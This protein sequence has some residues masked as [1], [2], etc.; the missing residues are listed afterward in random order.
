MGCSLISSHKPFLLPRASPFHHLPPLP[1]HHTRRLE[2]LNPSFLGN[3]D[4]RPLGIL[5]QKVWSVLSTTFKSMLVYD[6]IVVAS[7]VRDPASSSGLC[8]L[9][10]EC[11][12]GRHSECESVV[13]E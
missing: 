13:V 4:R 10:A 9:G 11:S 6:N 12:T 2:L 3:Q 8:V 1:H 5:H 7:P